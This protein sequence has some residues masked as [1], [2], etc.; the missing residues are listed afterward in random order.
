MLF[1]LT[2]RSNYPQDRWEKNSPRKSTRCSC[3]PSWKN[4][5]RVS[6]YARKFQADYAE[7]PVN[8]LPGIK[9]EM[10]EIRDR[11]AQMEA[12]MLP[13]DWKTGA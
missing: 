1:P 12:F 13:G 10:P 2:R 11:Q 4:T 3:R 6:E 7:K 5:C 8:G 9:E